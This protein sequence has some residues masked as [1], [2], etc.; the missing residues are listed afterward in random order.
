MDDKTTGLG[1]EQ[2]SGRS[3]DYLS[4]RET[5]Y[6]A[7]RTG[8]L[9]DHQRGESTAR[10]MSPIRPG[11]TTGEENPDV[12]AREIR[13]EIERTREDMSETVNAIQERLS[14]R[15]M[16]SEAVEGVKSA[17][18]ET[19]RS[20]AESEPI[21]YARA[22]PVPLA[23]LGVGVVG[24]AWLA[25]R[26]TDP[27]RYGYR[28]SVSSSGRSYGSD[29]DTYRTQ[30]LAARD[31]PDP[32]TGYRTVY[33]A[34]R[35][36]Y[37]ARQRSSQMSPGGF[38]RMLEQNPVLLGTTSALIGAVIGLALPETERENEFMGQTRDSV[39]SGVQD[40]MRETVSKVQSATTEVIG[41]V[42]GDT[43]GSSGQ[44]VQSRQTGQGGQAGISGQ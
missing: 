44:P 10:R 1:T 17:A 9:A 36:S 21:Q 5:E 3:D 19:A 30:R 40:T 34:D 4:G 26:G 16:V 6:P 24:A 41:K 14:P 38:K 23:M 22:N 37:Q 7:R 8:S 18:T 11:G 43:A 2:S 29:E 20:V 13:S 12:R 31:S 28:R 27:K 32:A 39:V 33:E 42:T 35:H 15:H 25:F